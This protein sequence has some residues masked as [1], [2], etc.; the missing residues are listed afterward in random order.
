MQANYTPIILLD[1]TKNLVKK[2]TKG[3]E[4]VYCPDRE[5]S[6]AKIHLTS[7]GYTPFPIGKVGKSLPFFKE[8]VYNNFTQK[9]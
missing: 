8:L 6:T 4:N 9:N 5:S 2:K 3:S 7:S 1:K